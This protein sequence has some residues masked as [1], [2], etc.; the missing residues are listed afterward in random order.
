MERASTTSGSH[1]QASKGST[2]KELSLEMSIFKQ[3]LHYPR[4]LISEQGI[5]PLLKKIIAIEKLKEPNNTD[6][7]HHFPGLT[8]YY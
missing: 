6:E 3:H 8:C 1:L 7:L 5:Q 4:Y 2:F